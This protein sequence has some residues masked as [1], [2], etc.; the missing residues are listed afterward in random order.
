MRQ[1]NKKTIFQSN[2]DASHNAIVQ[3]VFSLKQFFNG[4]EM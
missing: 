4:Y 3:N 2:T 1:N